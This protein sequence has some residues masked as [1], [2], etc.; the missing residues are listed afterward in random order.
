MDVV[1]TPTVDLALPLLGPI[2]KGYKSALEVA[3][4]LEPQVMLPTAAG[5]DVIF[6]GLLTKVLKTEGSIADL[7][8]LFQ[9]NNLLTQLLEPNPG[10]RLELQLAKRAL[11]N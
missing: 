7:R 4:W 5:G 8:L 2:I 10:D 11:T 6:E 3:Q 1:I 9:K